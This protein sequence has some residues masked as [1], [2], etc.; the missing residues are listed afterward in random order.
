MNEEIRLAVIGCGFFAENHL[1]AWAALRG[2]GVRLRAVCDADPAKAQAAAAKFGAEAWYCDA[3]QMFAAQTLDLVDIV[4]RMDSHRALAELSMSHGT[5]AV[6]QKPIAPT[7]SDALAMARKAEET[8]VFLAVHEN[9]RFQAPMRKIRELLAQGVIG[10]PTWARI[11]FRTGYDIYSGQPYLKDEERFVVVDLGAHVLDLARVFL[12][13]VARVYAETQSRNPGVKGEDTATMLM[14]HE[15]GAVSVVECTYESRRLPDPFP[16]TWVEIE[17]TKGAI[18][19]RG[20]YVLQVTRAG[21]MTEMDVDAPVLDWA[22][23][24]WHVVQESVLATCAHVVDALR[25]G[26]RA[27]TDVSDNVKTFA[28]CEAAYASATSHNSSRATEILH[29][30]GR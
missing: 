17:G 25:A 5:P 11:S 12:G 21:H 10:E 19:L 13:E 24:P 18:A 22:A 15:S 20:A 9:F 27:D 28:L 4:T 2:N 23:R 30:L 7:L 29:T 26:R 3:R 14:R 1:Q 8:G 6:V 16:E